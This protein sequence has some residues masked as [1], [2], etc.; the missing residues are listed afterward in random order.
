MTRL[1]NVPRYDDISA[2][3]SSPAAASSS[4]P[5]AREPE[6][7][8]ASLVGAVL[9]RIVVTEREQIA[10]LEAFGYSNRAVAL[11][12]LAHAE[13]AIAL[14]VVLGTAVGTWFGRFYTS[15]YMNILRIHSAAAR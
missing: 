4:G 8:A 1:S 14:G 13:V 10:F 12:Y 6:V 3:C 9:S 5:R 15:L 11:H 7:I 2:S